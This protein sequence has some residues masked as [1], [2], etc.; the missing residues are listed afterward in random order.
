[1]LAVLSQ[2]YL[3]AIQGMKEHNKS[4]HF[5][6]LVYCG[7]Y[8]DSEGHIPCANTSAKEPLAHF[9]NAG[10]FCGF[11]FLWQHLGTWIWSHSRI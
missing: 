9:Y 10:P 4:W 6:L 8:P 7:V 3:L 5:T 2:R 11:F 1:M